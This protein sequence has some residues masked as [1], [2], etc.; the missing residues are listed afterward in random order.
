MSRR[1]EDE[2]GRRIKGRGSESRATVFVQPFFMTLYLP[3]LLL[4]SGLIAV[5]ISAGGGEAAGISSQ[6]SLLQSYHLTSRL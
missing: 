5:Q 3:L 2:A 6:L 4:R 1:K